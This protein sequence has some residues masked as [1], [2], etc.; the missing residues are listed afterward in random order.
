MLYQQSLSEEFT[1]GGTSEEEDEGTPKSV[2]IWVQNNPATK[3][4]MQYPRAVA[5]VTNSPPSKTNTRWPDSMGEVAAS[6]PNSHIE[7]LPKKTKEYTTAQQNQLTL[8]IKKR[9]IPYKFFH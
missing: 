7:S 6:N 8:Q 2:L 9:K 4:E 3:S 5:N 1:F